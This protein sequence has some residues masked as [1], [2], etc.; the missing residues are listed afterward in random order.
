M[1]FAT[2]GGCW[3]YFALHHG[4]LPPSECIPLHKCLPL[5]HYITFQ[6]IVA[7]PGC[8]PCWSLRCLPQ[9]VHTEKACFW[10]VLHRHC[11]KKIVSVSQI[12]TPHPQ[13]ESATPSTTL[14]IPSATHTATPGGLSPPLSIPLGSRSPFPFLFHPCG[15]FYSPLQHQPA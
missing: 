12:Q 15:M 7:H 4:L 2:Q 11:P 8:P 10:V 3:V 6:P 13:G 14:I 9:T 1:F 5:Y